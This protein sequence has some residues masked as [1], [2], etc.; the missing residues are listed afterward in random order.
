M[1][2]MKPHIRLRIAM[3]LAIFMLT[4]IAAT[5]RQNTFQNPDWAYPRTVMANAE[6]AYDKYVRSGDGIGQLQALM[7]ITA[8]GTSIDADSLKW[9]YD[10]V[11]E[12]GSRQR[13]PQVRA[14]FDLYSAELLGSFYE[15]ER[16][17][18][19]RRDGQIAISPRPADMSEWSGEM[20]HQVIDSLTIVAWK[21]AGDMPVS[22]LTRVIDI[23]DIAKPYY[24]TLS[25]FVA[26]QATSDRITG[27]SADTRNMI[28]RQNLERQTPY[29]KPWFNVKAEMILQNAYTPESVADGKDEYG[30]KT[31]D[32]SDWAKARRLIK[33]YD[34]APEQSRREGLVVWYY[35]SS[36]L[37]TPA[38]RNTP[39]FADY[40]D[41]LADIAGEC[42]GTWMEGM[43][44]YALSNFRS[45]SLELETDGTV[46]AGD[47]IKIKIKNFCNLS[48]AQLI[49]TRYLSNNDRSTVSYPDSKVKAAGVY[50][51]DFTMGT[52]SVVQRDTTVYIS[53]P[54]G[55]YD[56]KVA[57]N[58]KRKP[59]EGE[60]TLNVAD[61]MLLSLQTKADKAALVT[62]AATGKPMSGIAVTFSVK[63]G[64]AGRSVT[65]DRDGVARTS[66]T[67]VQ[68]ARVVYKGVTYGGRSNYYTTPYRFGNSGGRSDL[69]VRMTSDMGVYHPGDSVRWVAVCMNDSL[70]VDGAELTVRMTGTD[71]KTISSAKVTT[72]KWGRAN[73][74]FAIP[75]TVTRTGTFNLRA[76]VAG[77]YDGR[78]SF[79]VSDFKLANAR[80]ESVFAATNMPSDSTV[81]VSGYVVS[82]AGAPIPGAKVT[83]KAYNA[84]EP[85]DTVSGDDGRFAVTVPLT[86]DVL[87]A[88]S[89]MATVSAT[90]PDGTAMSKSV[91][92]NARFPMELELSIPDDDG[93]NRQSRDA[94]DVTRPLVVDVKVVNAATDTLVGGIQLKW[95][96]TA[97]GKHDKVL[98][99]GTITAGGRH[100]LQLCDTL[101][102]GLYMI[103]FA[104]VDTTLADNENLYLTLYNSTRAEL[105]E[106]S[107]IFWVVN[108]SLTA[109]GGKCPV[110][111][112]V[113]EPGAHVLAFYPLPD[114][115][116]CCRMLDLMPGYHNIELTLDDIDQENSSMI[117]VAVR[118]GKVQRKNVD[119]KVTRKPAGLKLTLGGFR[120]RVNAQ[121]TEQWTLTLKDAAGRPVEGAMV[122]SVVDSRVDRLATADRLSI[123]RYYP[124]SFNPFRV[125]YLESRWYGNS[126]F[127]DQSGVKTGN[128]LMLYPPVWQ[129]LYASRLPA[130]GPGIRIRGVGSTQLYGAR[131]P[132]MDKQVVAYG[133]T[134]QSAAN[135]MISA[136]DSSPEAELA[137]SDDAPMD[138]TVVADTGYS[139]G[140]VKGAY[141]GHMNL[142]DVQLRT[143]MPR[144]ALWR[145]DLT[146]GTDGSTTVNLTVPNANTTW[147]VHLQG[148]TRDLDAGKLD[149]TFV[150][151]KPVMV[152]LN[153]PRFVRRGDRVTVIASVYNTTD[154][155]L[156]VATDLSAAGADTVT[157]LASSATSL[158]IP[159]G[160]M[161]TV[162]VDI[163]VGNGDDGTLFVT[164]R[165]ATD[166]FSDGER[167][168]LPVL[169]SQSSVTEALNFYLTP[170]DSVY[171][172]TL[173][174]PT[175]TGFG[176]TLD[177]TANPMWTVVESLPAILAGQDNPTASWQAARLFAA[178]TALGLMERHPELGYTFDKGQLR[179]VI[180]ASIVNLAKL[181]DDD[182]GMRW[183]QWSRESSP[184]VTEKML[185]VL[186]IL[187]RSGY[188]PDN[189][190]L[191]GLIAK[192]VKYYDRRVRDTDLMYAII[193]PAFSNI[194]QN[195]NG[196][197]V[198]DKTIQWILKDWRE[199]DIVIKAEAATA[200]KLNGNARTADMLLGSLTQFGTDRGGKGFQFMNVSSLQA[201]AILLETY[202]T[203]S[204]DSPQV[205]GIRQY[206][207]VRKQG[208]LWGN[209]PLTSWVV[210]SM[211]AAGTPWATPAQ[212]A[213]AS[214]DGRDIS[215][216]PD[217]RTGHVTTPIRGSELTIRTAGKTPAYGAVV[218]RYTAPSAAV[219]AYSDGEISV[220][221]KLLV[222]RSGKWTDMG[223]GE[224]LK[225]GDRVRVQL[226]VKSDRP[227]S[228]VTLSDDRAATFE[229]VEQ[230]PGW[231]YSDA[232]MAY[233][234]NRDAV[235]N[236]YIDYLPR[237]TFILTY[238]VTVNNAGTYASG[239]ATATCDE[240]PTLT[241]HSAGTALTVGQ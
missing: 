233:R 43:I 5:A 47:S 28:R 74:V 159:A 193:R 196:K 174:R 183:G 111:V 59:L 82:S 126:T 202:A 106:R 31:N 232:L 148:W 225:V 75:D 180:N 131:S 234:E 206:L 235:T 156:T 48:S 105:P 130:Y 102:A 175:G 16:W 92:Y 88:F 57:V 204:P 201:Y 211:I 2:D 6:K 109:K 90:A 192:A 64:G 71:N 19:N 155:E 81:T 240:A 73:G 70:T 178:A 53:L 214:V 227:M 194:P 3:L 158:T 239:I 172:M 116:M 32:W 25:D 120:D 210:Q 186:S 138:E 161:R 238:D 87:D 37:L 50:R 143:D 157:V 141:K 217:N 91:D 219:K 122:L 46:P 203:V 26:S 163:P 36:Q 84:A 139:E 134:K 12:A 96:L 213:V 129:Y 63:P 107:D 108:R 169:A 101:S 146:T 99:S 171:T 68:Y 181:Q 1:T 170:A 17:R 110:T 195:L 230:L 13:N 154:R 18:Y 104:P 222:Q 66:A 165:A 168:A 80:L 207:I 30:E 97:T 135:L 103:D 151:S 49:L 182:G 189:G 65:T 62:D 119:V 98:Q 7:Q 216:S 23:N 85:R 133:T 147:N 144:L 228:N 132:M 34:S 4:A 38:K 226:T 160:S 78:Y 72:D 224:S 142:G 241:A 179:G 167:V 94:I 200:L 93:D 118:N 150:A 215:L 236:F 51:F 125:D 184:W 77:G 42:R 137:E 10:R 100:T 121:A 56:V 191:N 185:D 128:L 205:D 69:R 8:A 127:T 220:D 79:E 208:E 83:V 145:P 212:T 29:S 112:G 153:A 237:G 164:A 188:M 136:A 199:M 14:L 162:S 76:S 166:G 44:E 86:P 173:P 89:V 22:Q 231:T 95:K 140:A 223:R 67:D 11:M 54:A 40:C 221:K 187:K 117:F 15:M 35:L 198:T 197:A 24:P 9:A 152:S 55:F 229:P 177:F 33:L 113:S 20:F 41:R 115:K 209:R 124:Y 123:E 218:T 58:G 190:K 52:P 21:N 149:T 114:G 27:L 176:M 45:P 60:R 39:Q 61:I